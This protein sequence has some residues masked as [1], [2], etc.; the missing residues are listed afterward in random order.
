MPFLLQ[1]VN[2]DTDFSVNHLRFPTRD[3]WQTVEYVD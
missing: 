3:A 1:G 2:V